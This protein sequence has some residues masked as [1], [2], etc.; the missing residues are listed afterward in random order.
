MSEGKALAY[1]TVLGNPLEATYAAATGPRFTIGR[2]QANDLCIPHD[3]AISRLHC[4][5]RSQG[6]RL[7]LVDLG[8][9]NGTYLNGMRVSAETELAV[10]C[11]LMLGR[12]RLGLFANPDNEPGTTAFEEQLYSSQGSIVVPPSSVFQSR[13]EALLVVDI[14]GSSALVAR[15]ETQLI[16]IVAV[17]GQALER[18]L[19]QETQPFLKCTGDGFLACFGSADSALR[20]AARIRAQAARA[21][22]VPLCSSVALHWGETRHTA[23]GDRGGRD[24]H[25][26]FALEA[27]RHDQP[28]WMRWAAGRGDSLIVMSEAFHARLGDVLAAQ[29]RDLGYHTLRGLPGEVRLFR[30][31]GSEPIEG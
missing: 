25:A 18:D 26:V 27:L 16:K 10:P 30:W 29:T 5:L 13:E 17:L 21:M 9:A 14:V 23:D 12:T 22:D 8:S 7:I 1:V 31:E 11:W 28:A 2:S 6:D 15:N 4:E 24:V 20:G 19:R 3:T